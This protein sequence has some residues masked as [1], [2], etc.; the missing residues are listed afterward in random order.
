M[1]QDTLVETIECDEGYSIETHVDVDPM[2][3][4]K[5]FDNFGTMVCW[6]GRY[7][8][9]DKQQDFKRPSEF[10]DWVKEQSKGSLFILPLYLLDHS[11]I[12]MSTGSFNDPWDSGQ[13]G[14]IYVSKEKAKS[15][16]PKLRGKKLK[17]KVLKALEDEVK[18]YSMYLE[19]DCYG[20]VIHNADGD[21]VDSCWGYYGTKDCIE[22]AKDVVACYV[23]RDR[24]HKAKSNRPFIAEMRCCAY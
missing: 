9:G 14:W 15:E 22:A 1:H 17:E 7:Q 18:I 3:P 16:F 8:L 20:H 2:N 11:G 13:V 4:R 12:S 10:I 6:H 23:K 5:E 19:G 21:D 24:E